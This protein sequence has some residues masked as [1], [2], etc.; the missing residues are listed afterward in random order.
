[1]VRGGDSPDG[2]AVRQQPSGGAAASLLA[3]P[4]AGGGACGG[5]RSATKCGR[6]ALVYLNQFPRLDLLSPDAIATIERGW[7]RL[8]SEIGVEF[9]HEEAREWFRRAGQVVDGTIVRFDPE[10]LL[11]QVAKA[12]P[13]FELQA[14]NPE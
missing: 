5:R 9:L 6:L 7:K 11:E 2:V 10:F 13:T 12:P 8:V 14:R 1:E 3:A 4:H